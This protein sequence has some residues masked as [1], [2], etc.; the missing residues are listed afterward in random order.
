MMKSVSS[1]VSIRVSIIV[2]LDGYYWIL[3]KSRNSI[4][5]LYGRTT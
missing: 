2:G 5:Y 4:L 1:M 3:I